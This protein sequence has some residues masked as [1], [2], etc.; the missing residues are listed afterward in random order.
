[1]GSVDVDLTSFEPGHVAFRF[2]AGT[3]EP[4]ASTAPGL[5]TALDD[6]AQHSVVAAIG[7]G[8]TTD[9]TR[10]GF[11]FGASAALPLRPGYATLVLAPGA[12]ARIEAP[13]ITPTL[14]AEDEAVQL[15]LLVENGK[16]EPR[17]RERG[18]MRR[19]AALCITPTN[20]LVVASATHDTSDTLA[21]ALLRI[22][23]M[24]VVELDRG[25]HHPAFLNRAGSTT[26]PVASYETSVLYALGRPMQPRAFRW[27]PSNAVPSTKATSYDYPAPDVSKPRKKRRHHEQNPPADPASPEN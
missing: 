22:G 3:R 13:G 16:V 10:Y 6:A 21:A 20:R 23:C 15:P 14:G 7:L 24:R 8:H 5:K 17:A 9:S 18:D 4:V 2:R 25:S 12:T 1:M 11:A 19:R 27:K 26:P